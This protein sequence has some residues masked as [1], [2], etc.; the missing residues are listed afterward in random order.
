MHPRPIGRPMFSNGQSR[1]PVR[2]G[3]TPPEVPKVREP[4]LSKGPIRVGGPTLPSVV[5]GPMPKICIPK[6]P[7][8]PIGVSVPI[9]PRSRAPM[10][11]APISF[12]NSSFGITASTVRGL[13]LTKGQRTSI[14][15]T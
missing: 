10:H 1:T 8:L 6:Q 4:A 7:C 12:C 9:M 5:S 15:S 2:V 13:T 11:Q 3:P 14:T